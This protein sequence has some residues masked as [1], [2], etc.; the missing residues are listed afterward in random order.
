MSDVNLADA[1]V[2]DDHVHPYRVADLVARDPG[3]FE[4][5]CTFLG[6]CFMSSSRSDP[7]T[8]ARVEE[9]SD[10]S[11]F[12]LTL[13][14]WL[15]GYLGCEPTKEAVAAAR[16][17]ALRADAVGYT[18]GLLADEHVVGVLSDEGYPQ[19]PIPA[20]E[21]E[22][23]LGVAVHRVA[24]LEPWIV[25]HREEPFDDLVSAVE[26]EVEKAAGDPRCVAFKSIIAYRTGLDVGDPAPGEA[27]D[28]HARWRRDGW[29][30]S[31]EHAKPVR[32]F[33]LRRTMAA[34]KRN[35][36]PVHIHCGGG[37]ADIQLGHA[38]PQDLF[39]LLVD[40]AHQPIV[41]IHGGDPW[42]PEAGY[43]ASVLPNVYLDLSALIPWAW[44]WID[45]VLETLI[46]M[47][48]TTKL[49]Y[50]SDE[51]SEPEVFWVGAR[52]ARKALDRTLAGMVDRDLLT[53][54]EAEKVGRDVLAGNTQRLH[55]IS[56]APS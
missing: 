4:A 50:G 9:L 43:V 32:D 29:R 51:A 35:D 52:I 34:A 27:A 7:K 25:E 17:E 23:D 19:P 11:I 20:E 18:T 54:D 1:E 21:F 30:E 15:A 38:R 40:H 49:L 16:A 6:T 47:V 22:K 24:R 48:P 44:S 55:G 28:A 33:L 31:R 3:G 13:R 53:P 8:W 5:R 41:L 46:G 45:W 26:E 39:P 14:R 10:S 42:V 2:V 36:R 12:A 37:D 56:A